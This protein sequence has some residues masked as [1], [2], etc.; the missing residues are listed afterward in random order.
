[1]GEVSE[2]LQEVDEVCEVDDKREENDPGFILSPLKIEHKEEVIEIISTSFY[3][4]AEP[5]EHLK[6]EFPKQDFVDMMEFMWH[7]ALEQALSFIVKDANG[8]NVGV[9]LN[10]DYSQKPNFETSSK[11]AYALELLNFMEDSVR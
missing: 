3:E 6:Y 2:K 8:Q 7:A 4:K 1:M 5:L 9:T 11:L 10:F